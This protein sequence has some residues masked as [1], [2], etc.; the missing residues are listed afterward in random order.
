MGRMSAYR[1]PYLHSLVNTIATPTQVWSAGDGSI[2]ATE[3]H[4][5]AQGVM[6]W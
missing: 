4:P 6:H 3:Q 2:S 5:S 1:Q